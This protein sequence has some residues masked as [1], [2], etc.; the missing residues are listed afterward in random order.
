MDQTTDC[1][2]TTALVHSK[3]LLLNLPSTP[4]NHLQLVLNSTAH[5]ITKTCKFHHTTPVIKSLHWLKMNHNIH[6]KVMSLTHKIIL[7]NHPSYLHSL[8]SI[9]SSHS[10]SSSSVVTLANPSNPSCLK[11]TNRP[12]YHT[13][14]ALWNS[15]P[16]RSWTK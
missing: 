6:Y 16:I 7:S 10:T 12:F 4:T 2:I 15:L 11:L 1:T 14:P 9:Q 5:A 8:L 13:A 3:R